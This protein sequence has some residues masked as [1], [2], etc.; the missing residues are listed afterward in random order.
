MPNAQHYSTIGFLYKAIRENL[1]S[2]AESLGEPTLFAAGDAAQLVP[3]VINMP[4]VERIN[5]LRT[6][7]AGI[8]LIVEHHRKTAMARTI[9]RLSRSAKNI[10]IW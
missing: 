4:G 2:L 8:D 3:P 6:A 10:A 9:G 5:N 1:A 7:L